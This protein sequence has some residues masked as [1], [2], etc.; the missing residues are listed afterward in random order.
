MM[1]YRWEV[2]MRMGMGWCR[3]FL[4]SAAK[5]KNGERLGIIDARVTVWLISR[6]CQGL[7]Q[8][9]HT[10]NIHAH[11]KTKENLKLPHLGCL[12]SLWLIYLGFQ[13][14]SERVIVCWAKESRRVLQELL[15]QATGWGESWQKTKYLF[16]GSSWVFKW[17]IYFSEFVYIIFWLWYW[18]YANGYMW[19]VEC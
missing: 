1:K 13:K 9:H 15:Q 11:H 17:F 5:Q 12:R 7:T 8:T 19:K 14:W 6:S 18:E 2:N 16:I 4:Y 3:K 10:Q